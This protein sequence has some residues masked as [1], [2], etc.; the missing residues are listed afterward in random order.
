MP[1]HDALVHHAHVYAG[2]GSS[3]IVGDFAIDGDVI[4]KVGR[5]TGARG[6]IESD[7]ERLA[8]SPGFFNM[9]S[10]ANEFL[11]GRIPA[12]IGVQ[13]GHR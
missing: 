1:V 3:P 8:A 7:A 5:L 6:W 2:D 4:T 10:W 13:R 9:L 12:Q 11:I